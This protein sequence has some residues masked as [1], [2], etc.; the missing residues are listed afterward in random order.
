VITAFLSG[1]AVF[2]LLLLTTRDRQ[3]SAAGTL[4]V[5]CFGALA[6]GHGL[7]GLLVMRDVMFLGL[8]FLRRYQPAA[9]FPLFFVFGAC[10]WLALTAERKG[11]TRIH[12]TF[13]GIVLG[14]LVFSYLYLWTAAVAWLVLLAVI[15]TGFRSGNEKYR[16][17]EVFA[18]VVSILIMT[19]VPYFYL[20]SRRAANLDEAQTMLGTHR[21]DLFRIPEIIGFLVIIAIVSAVRSGRAKWD[22]AQ[23][24]FAASFSLLPFA[25]LNQ[26]VLTGKS[27][28][29]YHFESLV[30]NYAVLVGLVIVTTILWGSF[31]R[32]SLV[33]IGVIC[34]LWGGL[35]V[36]MTVLAHSRT[37][38]VADQMVPVL[39]RL[40][41]LSKHDGTFEGLR[42]AGKTPTVVFSPQRDVMGMLPTWSSQGTLL[43]MGG[44][45]FGSASH[46]QRKEFL[47]LYLY[48]CGTDEEGLGRLLSGR[49][50]DFFMGH[51]ARIA[52]FGHE[53]VVPMLSSTFD[54]IRT[55]EI[56][57][58][59]KLYRAYI[60]S[61]S[62]D[63]IL[64]RP[65]T[66]VV[67]KSEP[68]S[69][70]SQIDRWYQ[71]DKGERH[72]DY[73]L[74]KLTLR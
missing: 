11:R 30:A 37:S 70:L 66:Y 41:E 4:F 45:D 56:E 10:I 52:I 71:R 20:V 2:W 28:Q 53:R 65:L 5:F 9:G 64:V 15:W 33:W 39:R 13:A 59:V 40:K 74:Y 62:R 46:S 58:Q 57:E 68:E 6:G 24:I 8:P 67:T 42:S 25:V 22:D 1:L 72:G 7:V 73:T 50:D 18:V 63:K 3:I 54:P 51:Y 17:V 34:C 21:P 43:S 69:N 31:V 23:I 38:L 29:P 14:T 12:S 44:L 32:R 47:Y 49:T 35:E 16:K 55:E 27:M 19:L 60:D 48:Y 36:T 26:Q 61:F